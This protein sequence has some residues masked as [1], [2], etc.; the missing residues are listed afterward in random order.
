MLVFG[1]HVLFF[2][3]MVLVSYTLRAPIFGVSP[4]SEAVAASFYF[5]LHAILVMGLGILRLRKNTPKTTAFLLGTT[6]LW[7]V[8]WC[9]FISPYDM[10]YALVG[11]LVLAA[12]LDFVSGRPRPHA[13]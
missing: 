8:L 10:I 11:Y 12:F 3:G 5:T 6:L 4:A 2:V 7:I 1:L 9:V 13:Q